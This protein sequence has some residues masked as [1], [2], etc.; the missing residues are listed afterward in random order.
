MSQPAGRSADH[1]RNEL[2]ALLNI[3]EHLTRDYKAPG[4]GKTI[5]LR[6]YYSKYKA[7]LEAQEVLNGMVKSGTW[8]GKKPTTI[9]IIELFASKTTWFTYVV[10]GFAD[11]NNFPLLKEWLEDEEGCPTDLDVWGK[12]KSTYTFADLKEEKER[13]ANKGKKKDDKVVGAVTD[14]ARK[15]KKRAM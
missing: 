4:L 10:P 6:V 14:R 13:R 7:C 9:T 1:S 5:G 2:I 11:I 12:A 15:H 8:S 3:P